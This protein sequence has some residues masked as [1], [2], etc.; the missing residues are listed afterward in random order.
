MP[1]PGISSLQLRVEDSISAFC[2]HRWKTETQERLMTCTRS[3]IVHIIGRTGI[4]TPAVFSRVLDLGNTVVVLHYI[5]EPVD[6]L[7]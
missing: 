6:P 4:L 5:L 3:H 7:P 2:M 1:D